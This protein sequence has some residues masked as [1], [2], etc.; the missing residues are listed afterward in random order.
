MSTLCLIIFISLILQMTLL[1]IVLGGVEKTVIIIENTMIV[2][3]KIEHSFMFYTIPL[4]LLALILNMS[5][6][7][8]LWRAEKT[9]VNRLMMIDCSLNMVFVF[10]CTFQQSPYFR[11][12]EVELYCDFHIVATYVCFIFNRICPVAIVIYRCQLEL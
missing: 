5:V 10:I 1:E 7:K 4:G 3:K 2:N 6:L 9:L 11:G 12:F 8:K